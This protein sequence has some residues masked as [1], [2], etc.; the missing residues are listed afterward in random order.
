MIQKHSAINLFFLEMKNHN[1]TEHMNVQTFWLG[2]GMII[3]LASLSHLF[4]QEAIIRLMR[5][6]HCRSSPSVALQGILWDVALQGILSGIDAPI[7]P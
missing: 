7:E 5:N 4:N 1:F 6:G 3:I 2:C